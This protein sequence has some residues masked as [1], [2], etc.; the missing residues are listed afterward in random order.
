MK[1]AE[2][3]RERAPAVLRNSLPSVASPGPRETGRGASSSQ[4]RRG[5]R[6]REMRA[7]AGAATPAARTARRAVM[8]A[9]PTTTAMCVHSM[10]TTS[11]GPTLPGP[12]LL[13]KQGRGQIGGEGGAAEGAAQGRGIVADRA[14]R[15][16]TRRRRNRDF[17]DP[18]VASR[19]LP[20]RRT[21]T[22]FV[23]PCPVRHLPAGFLENT[24]RS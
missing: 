20:F 21:G 10:A 15:G 17:A 13:V 24:E 8:R 14:H 23:V 19:P 11:L 2:K 1:G 5:G 12:R 18:R 3:K 6:P 22:G 4:A 7:G 9:M 16:P